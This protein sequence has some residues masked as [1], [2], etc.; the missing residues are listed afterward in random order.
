MPG[1]DR[2]TLD[3]AIE[4]LSELADA[5]PSLFLPILDNIMPFLL[6]LIAPPREGLPPHT[7]T[8]YP[9]SDLSYEDWTPVANQATEMILYIMENYPEEFETPD[10]I[11]YIQT[12]VGSIM[13]HQI[14]AFGDQMDC[15]AWM[16][17]SAD[18]RSLPIV[19]VTIVC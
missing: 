9:L 2:K 11:S 13:G 4:P 5:F 17:P 19:K 14:S 7:Y 6:H 8:T 18:V 1:L 12:L 3:S 16:D 10:R 15:A